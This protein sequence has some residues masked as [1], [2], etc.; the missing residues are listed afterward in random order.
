M[1]LD[2]THRDAV[3]SALGSLDADVLINNA[4]ALARSTASWET[5]PDDI[6]ALMDVNLRGTLNCLAAVV[7]GMK[8]RGLGHIVNLGS[9]SGTWPLPGMPVYA[10]T[11]AAILSMTKT[12]ARRRVGASSP[13]AEP[14]RVSTARCLK[15][16]CR[17]SSR[18]SSRVSCSPTMLTSTRSPMHA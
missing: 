14:G 10:M 8:A 16:I 13:M 7:P 4:S 1:A 9:T 18:W 6:D 3:M 15:P 17:A 11:K 5:A 2:I 12:L